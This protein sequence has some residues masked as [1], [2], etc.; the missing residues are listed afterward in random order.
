MF[1]PGG[2]MD[3]S[4][5]DVD[6]GE[7]GSR[8]GRGLLRAMA[9]GSCVVTVVFDP[10]VSAGVMMHV[11]LPGK[12]PEPCDSATRY[13]EDA[14]LAG[15]KLFVRAG[16]VISDAHVC[17]VGGADVIGDKGPAIGDMNIASLRALLRAR[18]WRIAA[19]DVGGSLRR[20]V[21]F[22]VGSGELRRSLGDGPM[23]PLWRYP[24]ARGM[25]RPGT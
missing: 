10:S 23:E 7:V 22:D 2:Y 17:L 3:E 13:A 15:E 24:G 8:V 12:A 6:T 11:M 19:E 21:E 20:S 9:V 25:G 16:G 1:K 14:L 18:P 5:L 4:I